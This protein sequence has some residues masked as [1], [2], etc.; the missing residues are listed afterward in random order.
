MIDAILKV[1]EAEIG[2]IVM[3]FNIAMLSANLTPGNEEDAVLYKKLVTETEGGPGFMIVLAGIPR[4]FA[5][6]KRVL[7]KIA[8]DYGGKSLKIIEDPEVEAGLLWRLVR[9][10]ASV[11]EVG[12]AGGGSLGTVGGGDVFP[13]MAHFI[14]V[15][16]SMKADLI[17]RGLVLDETT[18]PFVQPIEWGHLGHGECLVRFYPLMRYLQAGRRA[19][20]F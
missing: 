14:Q 3:G 16:S 13:L 1:G 7:D 2:F 9:I 4:D 17:K 20:R 5:H 10:T 6:K 18:N 15:C 12:R 11:R 19:K 8:E